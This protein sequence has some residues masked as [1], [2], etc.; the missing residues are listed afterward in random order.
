[1]DNNLS[2]ILLYVAGVVL[3]LAFTYLPKLK[4]WYDR[5]SGSKAMIMLG[6][7]IFV[8]V[9]YFALGCI[10]ALAS[11]IGILVTCTTDGAITVLLAVVKIIVAN[12]ATYLLAKRSNK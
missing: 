2:D 11:K 10:Q 8:A 3:S 6:V 5:Q 4:D 1:M 12:Q 9:A 7:I